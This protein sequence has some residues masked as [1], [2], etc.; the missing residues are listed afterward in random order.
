LNTVLN[1]INNKFDHEC[2]DEAVRL[3]NAQPICQSPDVHVPSHKYSITGLPGMKF[4]VHQV[5]VIWFIVRGWVWDSDMPG[6]LVADKICL[7]KTSTS[8]AAAVICKLPTE[9]DVI[10]MGVL[11]PN[12]RYNIN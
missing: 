6:A 8:V 2:L 5:W 11:N 9:K 4:L 3:L 7:G 1:T 12:D 10:V